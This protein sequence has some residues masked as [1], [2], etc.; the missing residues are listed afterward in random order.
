M[1]RPTDRLLTTRASKASE[2]E[3]LDPKEGIPSVAPH[4]L[5]DDT[6]P[7][8][9][10]FS[11][12][13][14][15]GTENGAPHRVL[16]YVAIVIV[17]GLGLVMLVQGFIAGQGNTD[18][19][20]PAETEQTETVVDAIPGFTMAEFL[21]ADSSAPKTVLNDQYVNS[22]LALG[23]SNNDLTGITLENVTQEEYTSFSLFSW[24]LTDGA[25]GL[26]A[27][28]ISYASDQ[29]VVTF[30]G[31]S[32]AEGTE[33]MQGIDLSL[34]DV[35]KFTGEMT[36]SGL[37]FTLDLASAG[38]YAAFVDGG[39]KLVLFIKTEAQLMQ[40]PTTE[41]P[42]VEP[43]VPATEPEVPA[44]TPVTET[45]S[46]G[47]NFDNTASTTKQYIV[48]NSA[49]GNSIY[50]ET[51]YYVDYGDAFQFSWAMRGVGTSSIPN[52]SA[53]YITDG[54]KNYIEV[55]INNLGYDLLHNKGREKAV[56]SVSTASSNLVDVYTKGFAD[57][58][59][60]FWVETRAQKNFRLHST[61]TY[62]GYQLVSLWLA[63]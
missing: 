24:Q 46:T 59:A 12:R 48:N 20:P 17:L 54:G 60:T 43:E 18:S 28:K 45:P 1:P 2:M 61:E 35:T 33:L 36:D 41:E 15:M 58:T 21:L 34:G 19:T 37:V 16:I 32:A 56:I 49:T 29:I 30:T 4:N 57:G 52:A 53:E 55:K 27:T 38:K 5:L 50:S 7:E 8:P 63:D 9:L 6:Q 3:E 13:R 11:T 31:L 22:E 39:N 10:R 62:G 51:Y 23:S 40:A 26:P 44:E 42:A 25:K 14:D 47:D